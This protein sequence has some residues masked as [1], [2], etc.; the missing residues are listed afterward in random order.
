MS[1]SIFNSST[2]SFDLTC[3]RFGFRAD[4]RFFNVRSDAHRVTVFVLATDWTQETLHN[5]NT[6]TSLHIWE[7]I[8][9]WQPWLQRVER[10]AAPWKPWQL[11]MSSKQAHVS[12]LSSHAAHFTH[13]TRMFAFFTRSQELIQHCIVCLAGF[14][15]LLKINSIR[16]F[17]LVQFCLCPVIS[18]R[19]VRLKVLL[20]PASIYVL[21]G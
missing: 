2:L 18:F 1:K 12:N 7:H 17:H 11:F 20:L 14:V 5:A 16:L 21:M 3:T 10:G 9:A 6:Y 15:Q 4:G 8:S 19:A 13:S